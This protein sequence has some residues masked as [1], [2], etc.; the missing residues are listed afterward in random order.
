MKLIAIN[1]NL[2]ECSAYGYSLVMKNITLRAEEEKIEMARKIAAERKTSLNQLFRE[3][4]D[5][6]D[7]H[8][9]TGENFLNFI[10]ESEGTYEVG[11][12][13]FTRDEMNE[14]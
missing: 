5:T 13:K 9:K 14:R 1:F 3:W 10:K 2:H 6:L 7:R 11:N 12:K 8:E 4:L